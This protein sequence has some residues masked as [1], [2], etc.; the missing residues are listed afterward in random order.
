MTTIDLGMP[1][2]G[3]GGVPRLAEGDAPQNKKDFTSDQE[4]RWCPG[5]GDYAVLAA[6]QSYSRVRG[7]PISP[8]ELAPHLIDVI[9]GKDA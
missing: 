9:E 7:L 5:C 2:H 6:V 4:V 1:A 3:L 8:A